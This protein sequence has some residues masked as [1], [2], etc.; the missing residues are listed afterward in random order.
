MLVDFDDWDDL[1]AAQQRL[2]GNRGSAIALLD[3][4]RFHLET[5]DDD[6]SP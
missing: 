2:R 6:V 1:T 4:L 3:R 5:M